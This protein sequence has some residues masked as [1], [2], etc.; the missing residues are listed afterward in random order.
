MLRAFSFAALVLLT[1]CPKTVTGSLAKT[2]VYISPE[3][4]NAPAD[5]NARD[6]ASMLPGVL[7]DQMRSAGYQIVSHEGVDHDLKGR[8][9]Y[10]LT[11]D[12]FGSV[13]GSVHAT[14]SACLAQNPSRSLSASA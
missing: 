12:L 13:N 8:L 14:R 11:N 6:I 2:T 10:E 7:R 3:A 4:E 5:G 9:R 1:A